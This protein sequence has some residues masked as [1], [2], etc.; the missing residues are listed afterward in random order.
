MKH[1]IYVRFDMYF[2]DRDPKNKDLK[3]TTHQSMFTLIHNMNKC[4]Y[5]L[6]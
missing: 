1:L 3:N 5:N 6:W 2:Y 4:R